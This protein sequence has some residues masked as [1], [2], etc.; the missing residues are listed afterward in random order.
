MVSYI[1]N[2]SNKILLGVILTVALILRIINLNQSFWLDEAAQVIE[3]TRGFTDQFQLAADFHPPLYHLILFFWMKF[4]TSEIWVRL[5]S[6]LFGLG[7]IFSIYKIGNFLGNKKIGLIASFFLAISPYHIWYSQEARPYMLFVF[8]SLVSTYLLLQRNWLMYTVSIS[9]SLYSLYFAPFLILGHLVYI[10]YFH[11]KELVNFIKSIIITFLVFI[12]WIPSFINQLQVGTGG[13][14]S[15]WTDVVSF[16]PIKSIPLTFAKFILGHGSFDNKILYGSNVAPVILL[17]VFCCIRIG[18]I[19]K[20]KTLLIIFLIPLAGSVIISFFIP[21]L[22]PQRL[23]FLLPIFYLI[24]AFGL[25]KSSKTIQVI[26]YILIISVSITGIIQYYFDPFSQREDWRSAVSYVERYNDDKGVSLFVFPDPF[27]PYL[28]YKKDKIDAWGIAPN[29][30]IR[31]EDLDMIQP[32]LA[33]KSRI[34]FFQYLTGL[35]DHEGKTNKFITTLGYN[36]S[37]IKNFP[38]VG[39]VYIYDKK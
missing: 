6:V 16:S 39:F 30:T 24:L 10:I 2:R 3:S 7:S 19:K 38:G 9:L 29:F 17:F 33:N 28:W 4:G 18:K 8:I 14:F 12:P 34:Y 20:G 23:L 5:L 32:K 13:F 37:L 1:F 26:G 27:A 15:G 25:E 11:K 22:A 21:I 36:E 31:N 35:T